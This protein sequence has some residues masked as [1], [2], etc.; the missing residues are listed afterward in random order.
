MRRSK[1]C[2]DGL[3]D[4]G[5]N[6][7]RPFLDTTIRS[8]REMQ[9]LWSSRAAHES[10]TNHSPLSFIPPK[11]EIDCRREASFQQSQTAESYRHRHEAEHHSA[12]MAPIES[13]LEARL[14]ERVMA[15]MDRSAEA[16][17]ETLRADLMRQIDI[18]LGELESTW[19][20]NPYMRVFDEFKRRQKVEQS[21][22][23]DD[24]DDNDNDDKNARD[25]D[26]E[27]TQQQRQR[28]QRRQES[29]KKDISYRAL[30][31]QVAYDFRRAFF[32]DWSNEL[33]AQRPFMNAVQR[34]MLQKMVSERFEYLES[35]LSSQIHELQQQTRILE[36][37]IRN[38]RNS[39]DSAR[40]SR[41]SE[42]TM[43]RQALEDSLDTLLLDCFAP[44]KF[45]VSPTST[46]PPSQQQQQQQQQALL[47][48]GD[49]GER[50]P[51]SDDALEE[52]SALKNDCFL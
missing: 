44:P 15:E 7:S 19:T 48:S 42:Q 8:A 46:P 52:W 39:N 21:D 33:R 41:L 2:D 47:R 3:H 31:Q 12:K 24:Y 9:E 30:V 20:K 35:G 11:T 37:Q 49:T 34:N 1:S 29:Q 36:A 17:C 45:I 26:E 23:H 6:A 16:L 27:A 4:L 43:E 10:R 25:Q 32:L 38:L 22:D 5:D 50:S 28:Q 14:L 40:K 18:K 13:A 51:P